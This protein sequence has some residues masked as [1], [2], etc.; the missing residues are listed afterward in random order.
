MKEKDLIWNK[1]AKIF[2]QKLNTQTK[3]EIGTLLRVL[4]L[5]TSLGE[6]Q[7]KPIKTIHKK[8]FELR[9]KDKSGIYR[10]IYILIDKNTIFIPH[11]YTKKTAKTPKHEISI[12]KKRTREFK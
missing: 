11:A 12:A 7:S 9:I 6:P 1:H 3:K 4:Q 2:V 10:V 5:R 8:A